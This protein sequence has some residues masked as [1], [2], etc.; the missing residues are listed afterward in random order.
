MSNRLLT[1][2]W[3]VR[4]QLGEPFFRH[5][6]HVAQMFDGAPIGASWSGLQ[7]SRV[8]PRSSVA[9]P[10][11]RAITSTSGERNGERR[12]APPGAG[13][14]SLRGRNG[15][16]D[17]ERTGRRLTQVPHCF[18]GAR[19][20]RG[21]FTHKLPHALGNRSKA[22]SWRDAIGSHDHGDNLRPYLALEKVSA[23]SRSSRVASVSVHLDGVISNTAASPN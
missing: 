10:P 17:P 5:A 8:T 2:G 6:N 14:G 19:A 16:R 11:A 15:R 7:L 23:C 20:A 18:T 22:T 3:P 1:S 21:R 9:R 12:R 4:T 13:I